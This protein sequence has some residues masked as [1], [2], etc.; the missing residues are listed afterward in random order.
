MARW[1]VSAFLLG[2]A[3]VLGAAAIAIVLAAV[4]AERH[5]FFVRAVAPRMPGETL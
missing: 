4:I 5:A 3:C 1:L 2:M